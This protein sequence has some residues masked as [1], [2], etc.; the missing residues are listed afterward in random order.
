M[1][2]PA[3]LPP[4]WTYLQSAV[5]GLELLRD[6]GHEPLAGSPSNADSIH[7]MLQQSHVLKDALTGVPRSYVVRALVLCSALL[8]CAALVLSVPCP[9]LRTSRRPP[10]PAA[11]PVSSPQVVLRSEQGGPDCIADSI[12]SSPAAAAH[13]PC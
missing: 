7:S 10:A 1:S 6:P 5:A 3:L 4:R 2:P 13:R 8:R 9:H 11:R 12:S